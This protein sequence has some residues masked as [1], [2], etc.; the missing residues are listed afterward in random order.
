ME[1]GKKRLADDTACAANTDEVKELRRESKNLKEIVVEQSLELRL[2]KKHAQ[3]NAALASAFA[4]RKCCASH[5]G[6]LSGARMQNSRSVAKGGF[7]PSDA[8]EG[9]GSLMMPQGGFEPRVTDAA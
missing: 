2:L 5:E 9:P 8:Q 7:G 6:P 3:G 1:A 4:K